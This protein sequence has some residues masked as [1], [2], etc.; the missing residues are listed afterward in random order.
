M[1]NQP[2]HAVYMKAHLWHLK[3]LHLELHVNL[4]FKWISTKWMLVALAQTTSHLH[5]MFM[6]HVVA[7]DCVLI[8][9]TVP[10]Q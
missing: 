6:H 5:A 10:S 9:D 8:V 2:I 1:T 3:G 7:Y 4:W